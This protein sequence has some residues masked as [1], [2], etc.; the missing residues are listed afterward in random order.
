VDRRTLLL[1]TTL[2]DGTRAAD[3]SFTAL[4]Q[5]RIALRLEEL[6]AD[7]IEADPHGVGA[8]F[9]RDAMT[10]GPSP[11]GPAEGGRGGSGGAT[12]GHGDRLAPRLLAR[13][14]LGGK[15]SPA[16][17]PALVRALKSGAAGVVVQGASLRQAAEVAAAIRIVR[18]EGLLPLA[19]FEDWFAAH[20]AA[21]TRALAAVR[22]AAKA[23]AEFVV[24][25]DGS[26]SAQ[27]RE[28]SKAIA[29]A[30]RIAGDRIGVGAANDFGL[31]TAVVLEGVA[32]GA[33]LA[34]GAMNGYGPRC[35]VADSVQVAA[36][37]SLKEGRAPLPRERLRLLAPTA[38]FVA[39][40]AN[41][42]IDVRAPF[43]GDAAFLAA[44]G[45]LA[46]DPRSVGTRGKDPLEDEEGHSLLATLARA[47]GARGNEAK[48]LLGKLR[49]LEARGFRFEGAEASFELALRRLAGT[50]APYFEVEA[51]RC[52][53]ERV[54]GKPRAEATCRVRVG[55]HLEHTVA[56][57][58]GTIHA[59]D[60]ALRKGL[61]KFYPSLR[62]ATLLDFK[63]RLLPK[64]AG[65]E[66]VAR[67]LVESGDGRN[68]WA[69][70]GASEDL[71]E[72]TF[73]ALADAATWKL[74]QDGVTPPG[75]PPSSR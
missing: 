8:T 34:E 14:R 6:G 1:D 33:R 25:R 50:L 49:E 23:G 38:R 54:E 48:E 17:D 31:A 75:R 44:R 21:P 55:G 18:A 41:H 15:G 69:T 73:D 40:L 61:E 4:D 47:R 57:A 72:A 12:A 11:A 58:P 19:R 66:A 45:E 29:A 51:Y 35:G 52:L 70:G 2:A 62:D 71:V 63:V 10:L 30:R 64:S 65:S 53:T 67:V 32:R 26:A 37:L 20:A 36:N 68:R 74:V 27:P 16:R 22:A 46:L 9:F 59:L 39:E 28:A 42:A 7:F 56:T 60:L 24:L 13:A 5:V 3:I 43:V